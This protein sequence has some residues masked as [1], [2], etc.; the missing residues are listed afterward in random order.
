MNSLQDDSQ[1]GEFVWSSALQ[2][3]ILSSF[4][5]GYVITQIPTKANSAVVQHETLV[6]NE[7][8]PEQK[9]SKSRD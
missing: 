6:K 1:D 3:Y 9:A 7:G 2:G 5:Y 8:K 4:F